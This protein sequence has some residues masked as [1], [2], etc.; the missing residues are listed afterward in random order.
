MEA[1]CV[2][3]GRATVSV[4]S[5]VPHALVVGGQEGVLPDVKAI[6][7]LEKLLG[8]VVQGAVA[9][10]EGDAARFQVVTPVLRKRIAAI[11]DTQ[12]IHAAAPSTA[13]ECEAR[14]N[15]TIGFGEGVG[16]RPA[17]GLHGAQEE[18]EIVGDGLLDVDTNT[19]LNLL[20]VA[21]R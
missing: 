5:R 6:V 13:L 3:V 9:N 4:V 18:A 2:E 15:G 17:I 8:P 20:A 12:R 16:F 21:D 10:E 1:Y 11:A 7:G 14:A 19:V